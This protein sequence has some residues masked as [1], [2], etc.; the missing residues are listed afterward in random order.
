MRSPS[1]RF[2]RGT[3][4]IELLLVIGLQVIILGAVATLYLFT[5]QQCGQA[6]AAVGSIEQ[7]NNA[8]DAIATTVRQS[9]VCATVTSGGKTGLRC[10]LPNNAI[11]TDGDGVVDT[12]LPDKYGADGKATYTKGTRV[13][14][15]QAGS[16][17]A[18]GTAGTTL[19]RATRTDDS[20]PTASDV[21]TTWAF[22]Y[23]GKSRYLLIDSL[24]FV[25]SG[26]SAIVTTTIVASASARSPDASGSTATTQDKQAATLVRTSSWR[27]DFE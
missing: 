3:T 13:W 2:R 26:S 10:T 24:A 9:M 27:T 7:A 15:Y 16:T 21:D 18:F 12:W 25:V 8:M 20:N 14:Y 11:D 1:N 22:Y 5:I 4:I 19:W 17:G 23:G 6:T